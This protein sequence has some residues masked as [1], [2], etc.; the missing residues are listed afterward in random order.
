MVK[1]WLVGLR[2]RVELLYFDFQSRTL[3]YLEV[4][5][6]ALVVYF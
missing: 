3:P 2:F 6:A 1:V 5:R 4:K